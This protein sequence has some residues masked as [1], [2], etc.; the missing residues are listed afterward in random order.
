MSHQ[1]I[2]WS[3]GNP[4]LRWSVSRC[5]GN[6]QSSIEVSQVRRV[7]KSQILSSLGAKHLQRKSIMKRKIIPIS[8]IIAAKLMCRCLRHGE[9]CTFF[10]FI[11]FSNSNL[12]QQMRL[13]ISKYQTVRITDLSQRR[14]CRA[15]SRFQCSP[16][17]Y[18]SNHW[19]T[20]VCWSESAAC[21]WCDIDFWFFSF[22]LR[23][24]WWN[25]EANDRRSNADNF[26]WCRRRLQAC[27]TFSLTQF[28]M[29]SQ[30][31]K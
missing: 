31:I 8:N 21:A 17:M 27:I 7:C 20:F 6:A 24:R 11:H 12:V 22:F 14:K 16:R 29:R 5:Y 9:L 1:R 13:C 26:Y 19:V 30:Y 15:K 10:F 28:S 23:F 2:S 18:S 25:R 3:R 4:R